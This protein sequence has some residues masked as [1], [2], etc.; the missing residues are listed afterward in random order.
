MI[1][2][3]KNLYFAEQ[4]YWKTEYS[5]IAKARSVS[6]PEGPKAV[7]INFLPGYKVFRFAEVL[8]LFCYFFLNTFQEYY[9]QWENLFQIVFICS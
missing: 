6:K 3:I 4:F 1:N 5:T 2:L 8:K 7:K 9:Q